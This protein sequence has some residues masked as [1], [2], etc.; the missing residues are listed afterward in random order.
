MSLNAF[1]ILYKFNDEIVSLHYYIDV[2]K[3]WKIISASTYY[4]KV[5]KNESTARQAYKASFYRNVYVKLMLDQLD[6][7]LSITRPFV[8]DPYL[9]TFKGYA[10]LKRKNWDK[11]R[12]TF[13]S[14]Q[15]YFSHSHYDQLITPL[16]QTIEDVYT[17]P[18]HNR[19]FIFFMS[20]SRSRSIFVG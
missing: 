19:Y 16:F 14:A 5:L 12:T 10:Y 15:S 8:E 17:V 13:I 11:A 18:K 2:T 4:E 7:V 9:L 1:Q 20:T 6:E 3:K